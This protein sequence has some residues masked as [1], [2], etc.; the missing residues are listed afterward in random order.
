MTPNQGPSPQSPEGAVVDAS[1]PVVE[2][3]LLDE[4]PGGESVDEIFIPF[5]DIVAWLRRQDAE[6]IDILTALEAE[7]EDL[8]APEAVSLG[9]IIQVAELAGDRKRLDRMAKDLKEFREARLAER[10]AGSDTSSGEEPE[11]SRAS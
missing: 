9:H 1:A 4:P 5:S 6:L 7:Q 3:Q 8:T 10:V 2:G 11:E